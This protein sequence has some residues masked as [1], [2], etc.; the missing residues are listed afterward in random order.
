MTI[1]T[2]FD[3]LFPSIMED[4][5]IELTDK[6]VATCKFLFPSDVQKISRRNA[7]LMSRPF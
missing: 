2:D 7:R 5:F 4:D 6:N 1:L 3:R